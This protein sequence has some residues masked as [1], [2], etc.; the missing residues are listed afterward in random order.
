M[1]PSGPARPRRLLLVGMMGSGKTTVAALAARR[2]GWPHL[3]S[4]AEVQLAT[5]RSVP[6][7]FA[8]GGEP[9]FRAEETAALDRA[10]GV[11]PVVVSVAGG[12]VLDPH[13]RERL[14]EAGTVVW[15]RA[16]LDTLAAR[17]GEG[18]GRPLLDGGPRRALAELERVRRDLYAQVADAVV[19]VDAKT[20]EE[21]AEA[22]LAAI[23]ER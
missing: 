2:L 7:L 12:A 14:R 4:D 3:D 1:A 6:E 16:S 18:E 21:V 22:A 8:L 10:L 11:E 13:N 17:V 23:G 20:P 9:A 19:D 15:L 5:G